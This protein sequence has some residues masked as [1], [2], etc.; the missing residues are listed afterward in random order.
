MLALKKVNIFANDRKSPTII[1][2]YITKDNKS[3]TLKD[4]K[5]WVRSDV[6]KDYEII[7]CANQLYY[8]VMVYE[9]YPQ[10]KH[11]F[12][13]YQTLFGNK[14]WEN[15]KL[16][17]EIIVDELSL[18]LPPQPNYIEFYKDYMK[19]FVQEYD[20]NYIKEHT[21]KKEKVENEKV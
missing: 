6:S 7:N 10:E 14:K 9:T 17:Q 20:I 16:L 5:M 15:Y 4:F 19:D 13:A 1:L 11:I 21:L 18:N 2:V 12:R 3:K 8:Q